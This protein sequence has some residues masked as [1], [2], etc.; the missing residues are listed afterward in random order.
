MPHKELFSKERP[1]DLHESDEH[2]MLLDDLS[3]T[4]DSKDAAANIFT[5]E[6]ELF[7]FDR[8]L[9]RLAEMQT[10]EYWKQWEK[11]R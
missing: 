4:K 8:T 6:E 7:A 5:G 1:D 9:S 11:Y 10:E 2:R 3:I